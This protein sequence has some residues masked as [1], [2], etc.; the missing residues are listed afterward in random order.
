[1]KI[2]VKVKTGA[3]EEF[4]E[5]VHEDNY[6]VA[7]A[8]RPVEGNANQAVVEA[9]ALHFNTAPSKI[10]LLAGGKSRHKIFEVKTG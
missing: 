3:R 5:Q 7:V 6:E 4:V 8:A 10:R 9:L 1:M 2:F